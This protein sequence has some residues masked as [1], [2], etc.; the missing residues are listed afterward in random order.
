MAVT[1]REYLEMIAKN[2]DK[3]MTEGF[4]N[5]NKTVER[6]EKVQETNCAKISNLENSDSAQKARNGFISGIA[7][8][9][10]MLIMGALQI[11]RSN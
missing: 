3:R 6:I 1:D 10:G 11:F 7:S 2:I 9:I 4:T 8:I 5:I